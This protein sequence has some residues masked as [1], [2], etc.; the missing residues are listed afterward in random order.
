MEYISGGVLSHRQRPKKYRKTTP[1]EEAKIYN[2]GY[3]LDEL[4]YSEELLDLIAVARFRI[5]GEFFYATDYARGRMRGTDNYIVGVGHRLK[6]L[7][8]YVNRSTRGFIKKEDHPDYLQDLKP[9]L[10]ERITVRAQ[11]DVVLMALQAMRDREIWYNEGLGIWEV[12]QS[13][14]DEYL[15]CEDSVKRVKFDRRKLHGRPRNQCKQRGLIP[16]SIGT[17]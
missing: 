12:A 7:A 16:T 6:D 10:I 4:F 15:R 3:T 5:T 11:F 2:R 14:V 9:D 17:S 13:S 8:Q 1:R